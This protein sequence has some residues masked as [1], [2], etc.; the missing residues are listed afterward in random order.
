MNNKRKGQPGLVGKKIRH[1]D[2]TV[3]THHV[4]DGSQPKSSRADRIA[5]RP[6]PPAPRKVVDVDGLR[7]A[8][9]HNP[10]YDPVGARNAFERGEDYVSEYVEVHGGSKPRVI[11]TRAVEVPVGAPDRRDG[12]T[13]AL[14]DEAWGVAQEAFDRGDRQ[15]S[16]AKIQGVIAESWV[17]AKNHA[18][19]IQERGDFTE[20]REAVEVR[21]EEAGIDL[22]GVE[23]VEVETVEC[24]DERDTYG[25]RE[26]AQEELD[27]LWGEADANKD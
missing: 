26:A 3:Q 6:A 25:L 7:Y 5:S 10:G 11:L 27:I 18:E 20:M 14:T 8:V 21:A 22:D 15:V 23:V 1:R 24:S 2:G 12:E 19:S 4:K 13:D 16:E 9:E 17:T